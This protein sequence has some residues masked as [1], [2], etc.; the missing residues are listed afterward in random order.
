MILLKNAKSY[1]KKIKN[2]I[3]FYNLK[4]K[5][6]FPLKNLYIDPN[7]ACNLNCIS[8]KC[9]EINN[10]IDHSN[11]LKLADYD[12]L[13]NDFK[14]MGGT[15]LSL[16]GG[17]PLIVKDIFNIIKIAKSKNLKVLLT[18]N[19]MALTADYSKKL[20]DAGLDNLTISVNGTGIVHEIIGQKKGSFEK[21]KNNLLDFSKINGYGSEKKIKIHF[22]STVMRQNV[23]DLHNILLLAKEINVTTITYQYV[24]I[25]PSNVDQV[26]QKILK[27]P[28]YEK[29]NHWNLRTDL[30]LSSEEIEVLKGEIK[31]IKITAIDN[32]ISVKIDP[33]LDQK[34]D[35][36]HIFNG[37]YPLS[38]SCLAFW[39]NSIVGPDGSISACPMLSHYP[40]ANIKTTDIAEYWYNNRDLNK[41][42]SVFLQKNSLPVCSYCCVHIGLM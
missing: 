11:I 1:Y 21:F 15:N 34:F 41:I 29:L 9:P 8:C 31:K 6:K 5:K 25:V 38:S 2:T 26:T 30:L 18:T 3:D 23:H 13:L 37:F 24:S 7:F 33:I 16:Y 28:S 32:S 4:D 36:N 12:K 35:E 27:I 40:L 17:E 19:G 14:E 10:E 42:R 20:I 39:E 22:H